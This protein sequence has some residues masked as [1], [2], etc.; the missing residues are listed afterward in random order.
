[1]ETE[2][3]DPTD[4]AVARL[5]SA[6]DRIATTARPSAEG[7]PGTADIATRLDTIIADLEKALGDD[8]AGAGTD[9]LNKE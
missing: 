8:P 2:R 9:E 4:D 6:L 3:D 5:E 1:M 7:R